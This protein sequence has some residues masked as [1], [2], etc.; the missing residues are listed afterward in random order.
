MNGDA[1]ETGETGQRE[2]ASSDAEGTTT[3][4]TGGSAEQQGTVSGGDFYRYM[5]LSEPISKN[6]RDLTL[7]LRQGAPAGGNWS[8]TGLDNAVHKYAYDHG[9]KDKKERIRYGTQLRDGINDWM[10]MSDEDRRATINGTKAVSENVKFLQ[11]I[12]LIKIG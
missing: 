7:R 5:G 1:A 11:D 10:N 6:D 12:G 8:N 2:S 4:E 9:V 3:A